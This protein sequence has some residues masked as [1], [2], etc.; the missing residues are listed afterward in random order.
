MNKLNLNVL[1]IAFSIKPNEGSEYGV[2]WNWVVS[3]SKVVKNVV[4][5]VRDAE[6]QRECIEFFL[7][8]NKL[9]NV[10]FIYYEM[11]KPFSNI[12]T[13]EIHTNQ[14]RMRRYYLLWQI[15]SFFYLR[16]KINLK[17]FDIVQHITFVSDWIPSIYSLLGIRCF[18]LGPMGSQNS[19][20]L[21]LNYS[22]KTIVKDKIANLIKIIFRLFHPLFRYN[23]YIS[24][25]IIG[26]SNETLKKIYGRR[27]NNKFYS[28]PPITIDK[29]IIPNPNNFPK[30]INEEIVIF[31][32]CPFLYF[33]NF[34]LSIEAFNLFQIKNPKA[35]YIIAGD[36]P[37]KNDLIKLVEELGISNK[38]EF[39]GWVSMTEIF[40]VLRDKAHILLFP[41]VESGGTISVEAARYGVPIVCL[42]GF[43]YSYFIPN[44][45]GSIQVDIRNRKQTIVN[46]SKGIEN[47]VENYSFYAKNIYEE[48]NIFLLE[49]KVEFLKII[50]KKFL[51]EGV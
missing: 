36:G 9:N 46:L 48:S 23:L 7:I 45:I 12:V 21:S 39:T 40:K 11:P 49:E 29:S 32:A 2:G 13:G 27:Y 41:T 30:N 8:Q 34:D 19:I 28:I 15:F 31:S 18:I 22:L 42:K 1:A 38:V 3:I 24:S 33:K 17:E 44:S 37:L 25:A 26:I 43:G 14:K 5:L 6:N 47:M 51:K 35:K 16:K 4:V 50:Y 10:K 20:P